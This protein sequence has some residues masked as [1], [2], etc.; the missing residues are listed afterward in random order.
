MTAVRGQQRGRD[1]KLRE[2]RKERR[3]V[4]ASVLQEGPKRRRKGR[5][6]EQVIQVLG[7]FSSDALGNSQAQALVYRFHSTPG[8]AKKPKV[9]KL[10]YL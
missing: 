6:I 3:K 2:K 8:V 5:S 7:Q 4:P 1:L 10:L 9:M